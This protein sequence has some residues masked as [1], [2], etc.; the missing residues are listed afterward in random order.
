MALCSFDIYSEDF[1]DFI[2]RHVNS[3]YEAL[4]EISGSGCID[5]VSSEYAVVYRSLDQTL[6]DIL[7][8]LSPNY[9]LPWIPPVWKLPASS[10]LFPSRL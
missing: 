6:P 10:P 9:T 3:A 8:I 4:S 1:A 2:Y 7:M 5:F